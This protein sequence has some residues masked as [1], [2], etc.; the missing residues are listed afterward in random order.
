MVPPPLCI[1][2]PM[3]WP[4]QN[5]LGAIRPMAIT[6]PTRETRPEGLQILLLGRICL[7]RRSELGR[8]ELWI[9]QILRGGDFW[10]HGDIIRMY[11]EGSP[12]FE[13]C[14]GTTCNWWD[15]SAFIAFTWKTHLWYLVEI[16]ETPSYI[17]NTHIPIVSL[18]RALRIFF[19]DSPR[20]N[21]MSLQLC[22]ES[23]W[24]AVL[25][26]FG[27]AH[28]SPFCL[29]SPM[30]WRVWHEQTSPPLSNSPLYPQ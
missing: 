16:L 29:N 17:L 10:S 24:V 23:P 14:R 11:S 19:W 26:K 9:P 4:L 3:S 30:V 28:C 12:W 6:G 18:C 7:L 21:G 13:W 25:G 2:F 15:I 5:Q 20:M 27:R 8:M 22:A 1:T